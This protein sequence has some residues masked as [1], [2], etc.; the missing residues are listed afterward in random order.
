LY[1]Q[2]FFAFGSRITRPL[3]RS[4]PFATSDESADNETKIWLANGLFGEI[5]CMLE[6]MA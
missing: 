4:A 1:C 6:D 5:G 3:L 2:A